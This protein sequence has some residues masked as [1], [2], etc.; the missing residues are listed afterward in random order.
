[1]AFAALLGNDALRARLT[2]EAEGR[3]LSHCYLISGP[4]GSG[5]HTLARLLAAAAQCENANPPCGVCRACRKVLTDIHPDVITVDDA[6][7]KQLP[8]E[9]IRRARTSL[10]IRP[11]EG[12]RKI[13]IFPRAQ[14]INPAGQNALLKILE[15]PPSYGMFLLLTDS[16]ERLLP[17]IRS[18]CAVLHLSPLPDGL[19]R[20]ELFRRRP[21]LSREALDAALAQSG[22]YLGPALNALD[23]PPPPQTAQFAAAYAG[24]DDLALLALFCSMEK[25][26]REQFAPV[27]EA[28]RRLTAEALLAQNGVPTVSPEARAIAQART[29]A[30]LFAANKTLQTALADCQANVNIATICAAL[31]A[32]LR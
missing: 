16:P 1:M 6:D 30:V 20:A 10:F 4:A 19:L 27:I 25:Y 17:T 28:L 5:K 3:R 8:V 9:L 14:D 2:A 7:H 15:E 31:F 22:G 13:L 29:G 12:Q 24:H 23:T 21:E 18:R 32:L 11:N 26:K